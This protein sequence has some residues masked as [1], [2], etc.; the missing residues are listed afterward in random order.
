[1]PLQT[2]P[3]NRNII[4]PTQNLQTDTPLRPIISSIGNVTHKIARAI[5]KILNPLLGRIIPSHFKNS[6]DLLN[7]IDINI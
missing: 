5:A 7:K 1:M 6:R 3:Y 2:P 4:W